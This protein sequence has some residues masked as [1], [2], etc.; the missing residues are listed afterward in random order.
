M[1]GLSLG[2][3][4]NIDFSPTPSPPAPLNTA[5]NHPPSCGVA[6]LDQA[7]P[8]NSVGT[9]EV[10]PLLLHLPQP[11]LVLY[12]LDEPR[13]SP[14]FASFPPLPPTPALISNA[15]SHLSFGYSAQG[16]S[17]SPTAQRP[18]R[19]AKRP[20]KHA[21]THLGCT[22]SCALP[23]DL[24]KHDLTHYPP[25]VKCPNSNNGCDGLFRREDQCA[26]HAKNSCK[27]RQ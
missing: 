4:C 6:S 24:T 18:H 1:F 25:T 8:F 7:S 10:D 17:P 9:P 27:Y 5:Q 22:Y 19:V 21:C 16:P 14:F 3:D 15:Q 2:P 23:K 13:A 11:A 26:R 20:R 12:R